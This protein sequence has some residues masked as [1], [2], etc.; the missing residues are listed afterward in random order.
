MG[1]I[2]ILVEFCGY[3]DISGFL[4][5]MSGFIFNDMVRL[6]VY[7]FKEGFD[8]F[9]KQFLVILGCEMVVRFSLLNKV[10]SQYT[11]GE[12]RICS[13]GFFL[14]IYAI[15]QRD[16]DFDFVCLFFFVTSFDRQCANFFWV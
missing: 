12:Q 4:T 2:K 8:F 13:D 3:P 11:L 14:D 16:G 15:E 9:E 7:I 5:A 6:P 1:K 10:T